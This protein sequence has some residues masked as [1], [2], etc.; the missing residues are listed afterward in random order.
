MSGGS[1]VA[2]FVSATRRQIRYKNPPPL[3]HGIKSPPSTA[4][5]FDLQENL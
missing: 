4:A 1:D 2:F 5:V 3:P